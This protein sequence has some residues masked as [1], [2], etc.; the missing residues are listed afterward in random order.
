[1]VIQSSSSP[2]KDQL[3][4]KLPLIVYKVSSSTLECGKVFVMSEEVLFLRYREL[5]SLARVLVSLQSI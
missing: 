5:I 4:T 1:M 3:Q 2:P